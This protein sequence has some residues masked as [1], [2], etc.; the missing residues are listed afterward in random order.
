MEAISGIPSTIL[1]GKL[2][3]LGMDGNAGV[4]I[5]AVRRSLRKAGN[6]R[7]DI[8]AVMNKM[9]A[10]D[11]DHLLQVALAVTDDGDADAS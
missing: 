10:G 11:Y 5:G 1:P 9:M 2:D 8:D 3:L 6:S 7:E 4:I